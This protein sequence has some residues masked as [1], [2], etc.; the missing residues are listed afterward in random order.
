MKCTE[1]FYKRDFVSTT[2]K[3]AYLKA[4]EFVAKYILSKNSKVEADKLVWNIQRVT[5]TENSS[6]TFRLIISYQ[7]DDKEFNKSK[8]DICKEFHRSFYV[9]QD[10]NCSSC[11]KEGYR[12]NI[13][14]KL[15]IGTAQYRKVLDNE[16][17]GL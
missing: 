16:L 12:K 14:G 3:D 11:K 4:C 6:P 13:E 7:F 1:V 8:C 2:A 9:N 15:S 17:Q 10:Y 5:D